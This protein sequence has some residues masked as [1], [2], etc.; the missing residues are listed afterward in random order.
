MRHWIR[1]SLRKPVFNVLDISGT[2]HAA[3]KGTD[4]HGSDSEKIPEIEKREYRRRITKAKKRRRPRA[5]RQSWRTIRIRYGR[6]KGFN[7][8]DLSPFVATIAITLAARDADL[9]A[10]S[11]SAE[12]PSERRP[13]LLS[14]PPPPPP[15][16]TFLFHFDRPPA[17][18]EPVLAARNSSLPKPRI[19]LPERDR[20]SL[21]RP[22]CWMMVL[23]RNSCVLADPFFAPS[24]ST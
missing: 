19:L 13:R 12:K 10:E 8:G 23:S 2:R 21:R 11:R 1:V 22:C 9:S 17:A 5:G 24:P 20:T 4:P 3:I 16:S 14:D 7:R 6:R 15:P 18:E